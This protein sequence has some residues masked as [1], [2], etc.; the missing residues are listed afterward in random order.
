MPGAR[1]G[2]NSEKEQVLTQRQCLVISKGKTCMGSRL[3]GL[4]EKPCGTYSM[5]GTLHT[6]VIES[7]HL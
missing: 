6:S 2:S 4:K 3:R 1:A 7:S 5:S